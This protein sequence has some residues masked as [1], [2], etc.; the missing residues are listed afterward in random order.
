MLFF[1]GGGNFLWAFEKSQMLDVADPLLGMSLRYSVLVL[2]IAALVLGWLCVFTERK[3]SVFWVLCWVAVNLIVYRC[4]LWTMGWHHP[5]N[6]IRQVGQFIGLTPWMADGVHLAISL[7]PVVGWGTMIWLERRK[8]Q[9]TQTLKV[10]CPACGGHVKFS[11][12]NLGEKI[13]C[14]QCKKSLTLRQPD[15][16]IKASCFFCEGHIEFPAH[17]IGEKMPC[18]HCKMDITLKEPV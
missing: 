6:E 12:Q 3:L 17:A 1:S 15:A 8:I 18:P 14:P 10:S 5:F 16:K 9:A 13:P 2:G 11:T 4:G 7:F